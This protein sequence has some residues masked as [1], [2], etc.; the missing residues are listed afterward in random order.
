MVQIRQKHLN[1]NNNMIYREVKLKTKQI[2]MDK[3]CKNHY[4]V[5]R[6]KI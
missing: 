2:L 1:Q 5:M 6:F 3:T 4:K